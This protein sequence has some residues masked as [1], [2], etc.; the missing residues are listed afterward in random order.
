LSRILV[1]VISRQETLENI[2]WNRDAWCGALRVS[3]LQHLEFFQYN[4]VF[5]NPRKRWIISGV[6]HD[7]ALEGSTNFENFHEKQKQRLAIGCAHADGLSA[8]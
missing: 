8:T 4:L 1:G 2:G 5:K 3:N 7:K 6:Q